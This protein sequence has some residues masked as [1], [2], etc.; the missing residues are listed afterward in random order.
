LHAQASIAGRPPDEPAA[1]ANSSILDATDKATDWRTADEF[2]DH[3]KR[4]TTPK[5]IN[6]PQHG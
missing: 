3:R 1:A 2:I 4:G 6:D 5:K